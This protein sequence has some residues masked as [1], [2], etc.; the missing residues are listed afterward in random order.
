[1]LQV[2]SLCVA[3]PSSEPSEPSEASGS[4]LMP[5][6]RPLPVSKTGVDQPDFLR[7]SLLR[8]S[9]C[10]DYHR[11]ALSTSRPWTDSRH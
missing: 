3:S 8:S 4:P 11:N 2:P 7:S 9:S 5:H 10:L 1:M 6:T